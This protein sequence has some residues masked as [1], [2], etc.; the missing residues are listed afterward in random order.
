MKTALVCAYLVSV[1][2]AY[3]DVHELMRSLKVDMKELKVNSL[4]THRNLEEFTTWAEHMQQVNAGKPSETKLP[5]PARLLDMYVK[6]SVEGGFFGTEQLPLDELPEFMVVFNK[7]CSSGGGEDVDVV[8]T[9]FDHAKTDHSGFLTNALK[10]PAIN[11]NGKPEL[12]QAMEDLEMVLAAIE[13]G[14]GGFTRDLLKPFVLFVALGRFKELLEQHY[15]VDGNGRT[16]VAFFYRFLETYG[17]SLH[18]HPLLLSG[19]LLGNKNVVDRGGVVL[20]YRGLGDQPKTV[21]ILIPYVKDELFNADTRKKVDIAAK[22][23]GES[24]DAKSDDIFDMEGYKGTDARAATLNMGTCTA[25]GTAEVP[26]Y[27]NYVTSL[28][29]AT[30]CEKVMKKSDATPACTFAANAVWQSAT[31]RA[32]ECGDEVY[33]T[34]IQSKP[35]LNGAK[36]KAAADTCTSKGR[37]AVLV[38]GQEKAST[39]KRANVFTAEAR[40]LYCAV[41]DN[42]L[43]TKQDY[44]FFRKNCES[45]Y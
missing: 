25:V 13:E 33:F 5:P 29:D 38:E 12:T 2:C 14:K 27:C 18:L 20:E 22:E 23:L 6:N 21:S 26:D 3:H 11:A 28:S 40:A 34:G 7:M 32:L 19:L 15:F 35:E 30:A 24:M 39:F 31:T 36:A 4:H 44:E 17:F 45:L 8:D 16:L 42:N 43:M 1:A 10:K 41:T 37:W 9:L